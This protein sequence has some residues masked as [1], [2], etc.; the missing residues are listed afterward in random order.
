MGENSIEQKNK[1]RNPIFIIIVSILIIT[2]IR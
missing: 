2:I 1:G